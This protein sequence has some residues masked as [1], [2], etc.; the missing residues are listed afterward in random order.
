VATPAPP[1]RTAGARLCA[2]WRF[3]LAILRRGRGRKRAAAASAPTA[4]GNFG[5]RAP[6]CSHIPA[7]ET[8]MNAIIYVVG[9]VVVVGVV[10]SFL[11]LHF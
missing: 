9:L 2:R 5:R 6:L 10:L 4:V 11:G 8:V 3:V 7:Q 1:R